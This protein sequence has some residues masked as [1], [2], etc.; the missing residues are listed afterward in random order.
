MRETDNLTVAELQETLYRKKRAQRHQRLQRLKESGRV[1]EVAGIQPPNPDPPPLARPAAVPTGA[2]RQ[3]TLE[4][5]AEAET[6]T[7]TERPFIQWRWVM[8]KLLL[9]VEI[10][11]VLG[12]VFVLASLWGTRQELNRELAQTQREESQSLALPTPTATPV[13]DVAILPSGHKPPVNGRPPEPGEAGDIPAHLLPAINAYVPPP[14]P[15]PSVQQARRIQIPAIGVDSPIFQGDDWEQ[16]KKGVGQHIGSTLPGKD[17]NLV[18]SAHN[19]IYG[20]IFRHLDRLTPGDEI[21]V[22]TERQQ[23]TYVVRKIQQVEPTDVW[24]MA[25]TEH[26]SGT[27]ISCYPYQVNN[28]R[29][30]VFADL[31]TS[32]N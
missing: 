13:I 29:L 25:P 31:A 2:M 17:G 7:E 19:D 11:A 8:N 32:S 21:I 1:V 30:I 12:L 18:L 22:E 9:V 6:E 10:T 15:T 27:L 4:L 26:A 28:K 3:Y 5:E 20:E 23:Y 16:L 14:V 24:V